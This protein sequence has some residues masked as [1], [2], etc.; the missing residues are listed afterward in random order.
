VHVCDTIGVMCRGELVEVRAAERWSEEEIML[1]ATG[2][3][4]E[5]RA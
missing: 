4:S 5:T 1:R 3:A 2:A